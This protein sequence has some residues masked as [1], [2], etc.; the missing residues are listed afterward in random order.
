MVKNGA[1]KKL[2]FMQLFDWQYLFWVNLVQKH[3]IISLSKNLVPRLI[4]ICGI[5]WG[6]SLFL[7]WTG[8]TSLG[9]FGTNNQN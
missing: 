1:G 2:Y 9:K 6:C 5:S 3:K 8:N 4:Q 7:F